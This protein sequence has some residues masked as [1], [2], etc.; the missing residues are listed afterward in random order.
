M[1]KRLSNKTQVSDSKLD[2]AI[3]DA[4]E[5]IRTITVQRKR[6][7]QAIRILAWL[8]WSRYSQEPFHAIELGMSL[9]KRPMSHNQLPPDCALLCRVLVMVLRG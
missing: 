6:L 7:Q 2:I 9:W 4:Q 8:L 5:E 3:G 1:S